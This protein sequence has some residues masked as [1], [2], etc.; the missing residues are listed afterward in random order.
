M[1]C[2][3]VFNTLCE[4]IPNKKTKQDLTLAPP[5]SE[6]VVL[7]PRPLVGSLNF[8]FPFHIQNHIGNNYTKPCAQKP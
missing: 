7:P 3:D 1:H 5:W 6:R 4:N 8:I 2:R